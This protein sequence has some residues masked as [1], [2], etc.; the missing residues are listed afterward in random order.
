MS[1]NLVVGSLLGAVAGNMAGLT[2]LVA[3]L[4][5]SVQRAAIGGG[6]IS[7]DVAE[8]A[9]GIAFHG[10]CLAIAGKVVRAT[11][12][13]AGSRSGATGESSTGR[14]TSVAT[15]G[16]GGSTSTHTDTDTDTDTDTSGVRAR[17][18]QVARLAA[19][20]AAP[21]SSGAAQTES[22]AIGLNMS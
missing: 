1:G 16:D 15:T 10:L 5:R 13:V 11:A 8:L 12:L 17:S 4:T 2:T 19:V 22:R 9:A 14:E 21:V 20:I 3:G 18:G 6:T 7:R